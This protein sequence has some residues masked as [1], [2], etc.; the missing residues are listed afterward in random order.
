MDKNGDYE[1]CE[2]CNISLNISLQIVLPVNSLWEWH[3]FVILYSKF[4]S[5]I[6]K[7]DSDIFN[8]LSHLDL[9]KEAQK[10]SDGDHH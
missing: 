10:T 3:V 1:Q 6:L 9:S 4:Q 8:E 2:N 5:Q 7:N